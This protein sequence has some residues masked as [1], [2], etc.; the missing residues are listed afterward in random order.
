MLILSISS[1]LHTLLD[2]LIVIV[3]IALTFTIAWL[4]GRLFRWIW[5]SLII[6]IFQ[7]RAYFYAFKEDDE[8]FYVEK[9]LRILFFIRLRR[10]KRW[11]LQK[12]LVGYVAKRTGGDDTD[13]GGN[14]AQAENDIFF[15][16]F[17]HKT[18]V[19][20]VKSP[21]EE[22]MPGG[23]TM[24]K[25]EVILKRSNIEGDQYY[26][27]PVGFI[28]E[29]GEIYKYYEDRNA[30]IKGKKLKEPVLIGY[31]RSPQLQERKKFPGSYDTDAE[32]AIEGIE[33]TN[34]ELN[35]WFFF[36]KRKRGNV[37]SQKIVSSAT[38]KGH[39]SL[40]TAGWRVLHAH[41]VDGNPD[42]KMTPWGVGYAVEDFWRNLFTKDAFG[43]SLDARAVAALL[44]ADKEG[45]YLREGE[46]GAEGKKG[47]WPTA[48]LSFVCYLCAFPFLNRWEGWKN[49]CVRLIDLVGP[50]ISKIIVL[51]LLFFG[52]WL[53]VHM[54]RLLFYDATDR[55]ESLLHKMNNNV[56]TSN[57]N[58]ELIIVSAIG[59]ILSIFVVDYLF[60]PIFFCALVV[61]IGQ[62][63][64]FP[65]VS[66]DVEYPLDK[67]EDQKQEEDGD[68]NRNN[69]GDSDEEIEHK[70]T[71]NTIG[72]SCEL[73]FK[74]P[75]N[76]GG[77]KSLRASN[78]FRNGNTPEYAERVHQMIEQEYSEEVYS[79]IRFVKDKI[80]RFAAKN[81]LS[82]LEK[83]NLIL[84]L[85]QP[86][87]II[88]HHD[89][90]SEELLPQSGEEPANPELLKDRDDGKDGKGYWEYCRYPS[91]T[92]HDKRGDCDCHAALAAGLFAACGMRCCY[93]TNYTNDDSCH[94]AFG[95]EINDEL[96]QLV[97]SNN[98]FSHDGKT[99]I[100]V[101]ATS[102]Y[103]A[104]GDVPSG[105]ED[106]LNE[107]RGT[108]AIIEPAAFEE[109]KDLNDEK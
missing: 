21:A 54:I 83:L 5:R 98:C 61:F 39:L 32:A 13:A 99:F 2:L 57:W 3:E 72:K 33:N 78:P 34:E 93:F 89:W 95:V 22:T 64:V 31:A 36:R 80:D 100:Y 67:S 101:E 43:F 20:Q 68:D 71:I 16:S 41:L 104:I 6:P 60:F 108:Y 25:C 58:T 97:N 11:A 85:S 70:A 76:K 75:Y 63:V 62:R 10:N 35:E 105:F 49:W 38:N 23:G 42:R 52:I 90:N 87:N 29:K 45:F 81:H 73:K 82:F 28:N 91:E 12:D 50:Q 79:R 53:V 86:D 92:L 8:G 94:A 26:D 46:Q 15:T 51:I 18:H 1:L 9:P 74:I 106:M 103:C 4:A 107:D 48:L 69:E 44:L 37:K 24:R 30:A 40:W 66:W 96:K 88:Y 65:P 84:T 47:L 14:A 19:G 102:S 59:L 109:K 55:F 27:T 77:L 7:R 17:L 56:G